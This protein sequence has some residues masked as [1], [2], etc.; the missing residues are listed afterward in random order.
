MSTQENCRVWESKHREDI[1]KVWQLIFGQNDAIIGGELS[2]TVAQIAADAVELGRLVNEPSVQHSDGSLTVNVEAIDA[3]LD[4]VAKQCASLRAVVGPLAGLSRF[5]FATDA[6]S[7]FID[8]PNFASACDKLREDL[9]QEAL[10][11]GAWGWVEDF[12]GYRF[13]VNC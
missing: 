13:K 3:I 9:T 5:S 8:A 2:G 12:D 1:T 11:D 7:G 6:E 10:N 4:R